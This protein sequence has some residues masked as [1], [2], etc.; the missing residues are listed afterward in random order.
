MRL[1]DVIRL[2]GVNEVAREL[3]VRPGATL[4]PLVIHHTSDPR[5]LYYMSSSD[6]AR[7]RE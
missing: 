5:P 6:A 2:E 4:S 1:D 3:L 7:V